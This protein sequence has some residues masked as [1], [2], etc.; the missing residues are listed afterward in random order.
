V[1]IEL[2]REGDKRESASC[3]YKDVTGWEIERTL[4]EKAATF[5][6]YPDN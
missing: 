2:G 4:L 5:F 1:N 6:Q 3:I